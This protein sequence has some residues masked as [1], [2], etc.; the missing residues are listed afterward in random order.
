MAKSPEEAGIDALIWA[1]NRIDAIFAEARKARQIS[2]KDRARDR[3][4]HATEVARKRMLECKYTESSP[5]VLV[6]VDLS[7]IIEA[8]DEAWDL[9]GD[10]A[11]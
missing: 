2:P 11:P 10:D 6:I 5:L 7:E 3:I 1:Q 9:L 4:A 8:L